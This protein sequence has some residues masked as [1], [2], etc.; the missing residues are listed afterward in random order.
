[1]VCLSYTYTL[2]FVHHNVIVLISP[3]AYDPNRSFPIDIHNPGVEKETTTIPVTNEVLKQR[4]MQ[5][6]M[7]KGPKSNPFP[8]HS[9]GDQLNTKWML[10]INKQLHDLETEQGVQGEEIVALKDSIK[11]LQD[12]HKEN[13]KAYKASE[14][15]NQ[16][17]LAE[18]AK[19]QQELTKKLKNATQGLDRNAVAA[20]VEVREIYRIYRTINILFL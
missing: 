19:F 18:K 8:D 5:W 9:V 16:R 13:Q 4:L 7:T 6:Q 11:S 15:S 14:R 12:Q 10:E 1:M 20:I 17:L 3:R 2:F